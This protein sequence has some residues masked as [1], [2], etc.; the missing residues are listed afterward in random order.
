MK[1]YSN[2]ENEMA[3][4]KRQYAQMLILTHTDNRTRQ[5]DTR[6]GQYPLLVPCYF[7]KTTQ[8]YARHDPHAYSS[9][10]KRVLRPWYLN[11]CPSFHSYNKCGKRTFKVWPTS[12]FCIASVIK[13]KS[14]DSQTDGTSWQR[15]STC[16]TT[17]DLTST[18]NTETKQNFHLTGTHTYS[19]PGTRQWAL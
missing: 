6:H 7:R 13:P 1:K 9:G 10:R 5:Q 8:A 12:Q 17:I 18:V 16:L 11:T 4:Q 3:I 14:K 2:N 15:P 19:R